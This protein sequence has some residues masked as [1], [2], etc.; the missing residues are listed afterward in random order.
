[1]NFKFTRD[2]VW[3]GLILFGFFSLA[4]IISALPFWY[5]ATKHG[6][7]DAQYTIIFQALTEWYLWMLFIPVIYWISKTFPIHTSSLFKVISIN[8]LLSLIIIICKILIDKFMQTLFWNKDLTSKPLWDVILY[9]FLSPNTIV[10]LLTYGL[11]LMFIYMIRYYKELQEH[12]LISSQLEAQLAQAHLSA[13]K[14]QIQP[15]F[16]FNTLNSIISLL[17]KDVDAAEDMILNLSDML[18]YTLN[19]TNIQEV[20]LRE[21]IDFLHHYLDIESKRFQDRLTTEFQIAEDTLD[22]WVPSM[23]LQPIVENSI[24]HGIFKQ[25]DS[26]KITILS[27]RL[28]DTLRV[29]VLDTGVGF[30]HKQDEEGIGLGN[31]RKRLEKLYGFYSDLQFSRTENNETIVTITIP[32]TE[33]RI[34]K[35]VNDHESS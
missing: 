18:R 19:T 23:F 20:T 22:A 17:R 32:F 30:I 26:G 35:E 9:S 4:G 6:K 5:F 28:G 10:L 25:I 8:F 13:L 24:R 14:K 11:I 7:Y 1:M 21:E 3:K 34:I 12:D 29:S 31:T 16:L 27:Q 33:R 15:H 2:H